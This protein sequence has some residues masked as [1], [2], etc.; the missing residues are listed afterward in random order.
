MHEFVTWC[1]YR[2]IC[3]ADTVDYVLGPKSRQARSTTDEHALVTRVS[4]KR[5]LEPIRSGVLEL[6]T[7]HRARRVSS[8]ASYRH[9]VAMGQ[10]RGTV[11]VSLVKVSPAYQK[12]KKRSYWSVKA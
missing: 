3:W 4:L 5:T 2:V 9:V 6:C 12:K 7:L 1:Y 11:S 10:S 8:L